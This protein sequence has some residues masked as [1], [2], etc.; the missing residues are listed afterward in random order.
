MTLALCKDHNPYLVTVTY[1]FDFEKYSFYFHCAT[2][3]RKLDYIEANPRVYGQILEDDG[4]MDGMCL[5]AFKTVQFTGTAKIIIDEKI[6]RR[7]LSML[8]EKH[9]SN[10]ERSRERF[11]KQGKI[12]KTAIIEIEVYSF[13]GKKINRS[14]LDSNV[15][16]KI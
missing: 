5:H 2:K 12:E 6:K 8:I 4:Y 1:V 16:N 14:L 15:E 9:E 10:P 7:A 13:S 11:M 3:G